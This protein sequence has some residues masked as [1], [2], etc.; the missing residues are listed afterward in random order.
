[1]NKSSKILY[2][3]GSGRLERIKSKDIKTY[4]FFY[5]YFHLKN[6]FSIDIV[7]MLE[8]K[9]PTKLTQK[10]LLFVDKVLRKFTNLPFYF[11]LIISWT[12]LKKI[13]KADTIIST[14][15]RLALSVLPLVIIVKLFKKTKLNIIVMG[16]FG[17]NK[18]NIV[19]K[20]LQNTIIN[21]LLYFSN[22]LIFLG[23]AE[24]E[25]ANRQFSKF[26]K[27]FVFIPFGIDTLFWKS[28]NT[29]NF[30]NKNYILFLGNDG[31]RD[32]DLVYKIASKLKDVNFK[33]VTKYNFNTLESLHN[34]DIISGDWNANLLSDEAIKEY[35]ENARM[36]ILPLK[37]SLQ[38]SGQS[39]TLQSMS[40][41][42]PVA[43][44]K[45][46]GF[47]DYSKFINNEN[48][49]FILDNSLESWLNFLNSS[50][51]D[52]DMLKKISLNSV[53]TVS[54]HFDQNQFNEKLI[55][56]INTD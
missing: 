10:I 45:T 37:D 27:K 43:I 54:K 31:N 40:M 35:Y 1:M 56:I 6:Q 25:V 28:R 2:I 49:F 42:T 7:E 41:G 26:K 11:N 4:E 44:T 14:N 30:D 24:Y 52:T 38:P 3:F 17:K 47:W 18:K 36:T 55:E 32:Y 12:N 46:S 23:N 51:Y 8:E 19:I 15:D 16:L 53:S 22:K 29:S 13:W 50:Y 20:L 21:T 34:V 33:F 48:I 39:V 5:G 9:P